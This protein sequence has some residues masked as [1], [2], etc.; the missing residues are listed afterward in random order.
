MSKRPTDQVKQTVAPSTRTAVGPGRANVDA[1][2]K[3]HRKPVPSGHGVQHS[4]ERIAKVKGAN[5]RRYGRH[6][7][8]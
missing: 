8:G 7:R 1:P 3:R 2:G 6:R 5:E 4:D